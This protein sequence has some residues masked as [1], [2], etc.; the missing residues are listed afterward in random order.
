MLE[1]TYYKRDSFQ[2]WVVQS[3]VKGVSAKFDFRY[4]SLRSKFRFILFVYNLMIGC[5]KKK[6]E[7]YLGKCFRQQKKKPGLKFNPGLSLI[8]L[9]TTGP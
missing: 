6:K 9:R 1:G 4:E 3:R 8:S 2:G 5:S 7:N